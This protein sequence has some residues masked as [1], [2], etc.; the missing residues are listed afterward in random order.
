MKR[1]CLLALGL[2]L[3]VAAC[4]DNAGPTDANSPNLAS[5]SL[6]GIDRYNV[7]LK[8]PA[9]AGQ[10]TELARHGTI[11]GELAAINAVFMRAKAEKVAAIR[12]LPFVAGVSQ[13]Q[14]R[15]APPGEVLAE[16][17]SPSASHNVWNLDAI[18]VTE[19]DATY[20]GAAERQVA[21]NGEGVVVAVLD[22]G[23]MP[24]WPFYFAGKDV[25]T[26]NSTTLLGGG[27]SDNG[28]VVSPKN[29]WQ[30]DVRGHGTHVASIITGFQY[31]AAS[32]GGA[33]QIDG[34]A[35]EVT[36]VVVKVLN[37]N[38]GGWTSGVA[39]GIIYATDL[40]GTGGPHAGKRLVINMSLGGSQLDVVERA[41]LDYAVNHGVVVVASAG[42]SGPAGNLGFPGGY[43]RVISAA[44]AGWV[45]EWNN[46]GGNNPPNPACAKLPIAAD[47]LIPSRFWRQCDV[48]E[49]YRS[50]NFY[51]SSFSARDPDGLDTGADFDLD[52]AAP[53]SWVVGPWG[54]NNGQ[55]NYA[56]VGG[57]SQASPHVAGIVA[58]ML[59]KN[60]GLTPAQI[61]S[62]LETAAQLLTDSNQQVS[63]GPLGLVPASPI[64]PPSWGSDRSGHGF[65]TADAALACA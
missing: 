43:E 21:Q 27:A 33:F 64:T 31:A 6:N 1:N 3:F 24:F 37:Q 34:V 59:Q 52:V 7:L 4:G 22:T 51:I 13:D 53:G 14:P 41:A 63:P 58:L 65:I 36:L 30:G 15:N 25:D 42:N 47:A 20:D 29:K 40:V 8:G 35:P 39:Q 19:F 44:S 49:P 23:L 2:A 16:E 9:T 18:N 46:P 50:A 55:L 10:R 48:A 61:E 56:F 28:A 60:P 12:A 32:T 11:Y 5:R 45:G 57:T 54:F 38:G 62:C 26:E 17:F